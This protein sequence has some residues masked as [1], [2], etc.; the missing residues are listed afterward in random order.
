MPLTVKPVQGGLY[1][2]HD[3]QV[4]QIGPAFLS[5]ADAEHARRQFAPG[6][7]LPPA[8]GAAALA[9]RAGGGSYDVIDHMAQVLIEL[10]G[11][12]GGVTKDDLKRAGFTEA[13]VMAHI[14][15]ARARAARLS[16]AA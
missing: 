16:S 8:P 4:G 12:G 9:A 3:D 2:L 13:E 6:G 14:D 7:G 15:D 11:N 5:A 10:T 1:A